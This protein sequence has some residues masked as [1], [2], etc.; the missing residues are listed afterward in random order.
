MS[1]R[2]NPGCLLRSALAV[3]GVIFLP[4]TIWF[5]VHGRWAQGIVL[6]AV[7]V[8]FLRMAFDRSEDSWITAVDD[9]G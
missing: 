7:S 6:L 3:F 1:R 8:F 9:L 2:F 4:F 5:L